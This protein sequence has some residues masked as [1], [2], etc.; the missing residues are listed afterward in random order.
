VR[1]FLTILFKHK[2]KII[3]VSL[4]IISLVTA[5]SFMLPP[6]YEASSSLMVKFG[7]EY[8]YRSEV[9]DMRPPVI[10]FNR[11]ESINSEIEILK[12]R[13]LLEKVISALGME[14][15]YPDLTANP[16]KNI[17]LMD[18]AVLRFQ[19]RV[20]A[21][22]ITKSNVIQVSFQH[23]SPQVA[24]MVVN[25]LVEF[26]KEKHLE[27]FSE[28][29]ASFL[30][31]QL[32]IYR[33]NLDK[34]EETLVAFKQEHNLVSLEEQRLLLLK[35]RV[36][37]DTDL[38]NAE[39]Q[40]TQFEEK[41]SSL[42]LQMKKI[43]ENIPLY[44]E[45]ERYEII[46]DAKGELLSLQLKEQKLL[47]KHNENSRLV[48]NVRKEIALV[49]NFLDQQEKEIK[50]K[51]RIGKNSVY[52][53]IEK[54]MIQTK[55]ELSSFE[56]K[57]K[58]LRVQIAS[59]DNEIKELDRQEKDLRQLERERALNEENY[60]T[61]MKKLEE[62]RITAEM[63]QE[64]MVSVRVIQTATVP[65]KPVKPNKRLNIIL[66]VVL[67]I[68]SGL[69]VAFSSEYF[70]QR[71]SSPEM[72]ESRLELPVLATVSYKKGVMTP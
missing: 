37:L 5:A 30:G 29:R 70:G 64:K 68:S 72:A 14:R 50:G 13:D 9:D 31:K 23:E 46:D 45:T 39:N 18:A 43:S 65:A 71:V 24:A 47:G 27:I 62:S 20:S 16:P 42:K 19:K 63:D 53:E 1:N 44:Q 67:G 22:S 51:V 32:A 12:S 57:M 54:E 69:L 10:Q 58:T 2:Y 17:T 35:Q 52:Q 26:F 11:E 41:I 48:V 61:Y 8:V 25:K 49:K 59:L 60:Q 66:G 4:T 28:S 38:K 34:S 56:A 7:R 55:A 15:I 33:Q 21:K 36:E 40:T 6:T 3:A